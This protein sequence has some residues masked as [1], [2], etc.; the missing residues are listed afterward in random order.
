VQ[1]VV[2]CEF[3]FFQTPDGK[4]WTPSAFNS[5]FWLRYLTVFSSVKVVARVQAVTCSEASWQRSDRENVYFIALPYY[6]GF[7]GLL[8]NARHI[9]RTLTESVSENE[10]L[11]F[12][13]PSQTSTLAYWF[14]GKGIGKYALEV[15]GDPADVFSSGITNGLAD[16]VLG[17]ISAST[18]RKLCAK[19]VAASYV[20]TRYLQLKYPVNKG[21]YQVACSSIELHPNWIAESP[22]SFDKPARKLLFVGS[23]GQLYKGQDTLLKAIALLRERNIN[24]DLVMLGGGI[25]LTEMKKLAESL[26]IARSVS[27][28]GEVNA[29]QVKEALGLAD[30][31][32]MPSRTEGLP[33]AL[34]EAMATGLPAIGSKVGG[35]PELLPEEHLFDSEDVAQLANKLDDLSNCTSALNKASQVNIETAKLYRSSVLSQRRTDFYNAVK[36]AFEHKQ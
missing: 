9:V 3:R 24:I 11:I 28:V 2:T 13:V 23:F 1:V 30:F 20:T 32:V 36:E 17:W 21:V 35:I 34:I 19:A 18:L 15:V 8:R 12:R 6:V 26:G 29:D 33:R 14:A 31:F 22:K 16:K 27:F 7:A 5:D 25:Y 4:V 10:A